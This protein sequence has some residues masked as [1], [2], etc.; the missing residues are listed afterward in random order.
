MCLI[1]AFA[2]AL[3]LLWQD[4]IAKSGA[5]GFMTYMI[6]AILIALWKSSCNTDEREQHR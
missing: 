1:S 2:G 3:L 6:A 5:E 4:P